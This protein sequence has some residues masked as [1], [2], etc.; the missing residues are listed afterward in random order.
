[1]RS[2]RQ[3]RV[4]GEA[5]PRRRRRW[6]RL[7]SKLALV[8][9]LL[10]LLA[11]GL[12][13]CNRDKTTWATGSGEPLLQMPELPN[14]CEITSLTMLLQW[15]GVPAEKTDLAQNWLPREP[16]GGT[17]E[18]PTGQNPEQAYA[19]DPAQE[20]S[21]YCFEGPILDAANGYLDYNH[22]AWRA[23][24]LT[25]ISKGELNRM[26]RNGTPM[27]VWV[28]LDYGEPVLSTDFSWQLPDGSTYQPYRNLH[29][30]VLEGMVR[31]EYRIADPLYGWQTVDR[32]QFWEAFSALGC[33]AVALQHVERD[34]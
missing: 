16:F 21:W 6:G 9:M 3:E 22:Q 4:Y 32:D 18:E 7:L 23:V 8:L 30:V 19:G 34:Q 12:Q 17:E 26:V 15:A 2:G 33:R 20:G 10:L 29:C 25:G 13:C 1:M 14:G 31:D 11:V 27:A 5:R 24:S 28:T